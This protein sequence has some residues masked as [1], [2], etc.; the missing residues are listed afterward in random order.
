MICYHFNENNLIIS[1]LIDYTILWY[2]LFKFDKSIHPNNSV[3]PPIK[4]TFK[5]GQK[6][7]MRMK[8]WFQNGI[9]LRK[10]YNNRIFNGLFWKIYAII[11]SEYM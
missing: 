10:L 1:I 11:M 6:L 2:P 4:A 3:F 8:V 5:Q 7:S 9:N